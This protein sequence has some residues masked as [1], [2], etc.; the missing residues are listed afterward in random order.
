VSQCVAW[1]GNNIGGSLK[2]SVGIAMQV[3]FGNLG[4]AISG[5][6]YLT[7]DSPHFRQGH[8]TLIGMLSMS[9]ALCVF[10]RIWM[11]WENKKRD[12]RAGGR[13]VGDYSKEELE[14]ERHMGDS[15]TFFRYTI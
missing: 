15:A 7:R 2:R 6:M 4:G 13:K 14:R 10:M 11:A 8:G 1:N 3:G 5:Y 9:T 12:E